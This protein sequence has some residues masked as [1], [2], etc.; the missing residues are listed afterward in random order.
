MVRFSFWNQQLRNGSDIFGN[1]SK[2][3]INLIGT[4]VYGHIQV[5]MMQSISKAFPLEHKFALFR[6]PNWQ[7][8]DSLSVNHS[9]FQDFTFSTLCMK[10]FGESLAKLQCLYYIVLMQTMPLSE[11]TWRLTVDSIKKLDGDLVLKLR[12]QAFPFQIVVNLPPHTTM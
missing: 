5:Q 10:W 6:Q 11:S 4:H 1:S 8:H 2:L 12:Y 7:Y 3:N 9:Q